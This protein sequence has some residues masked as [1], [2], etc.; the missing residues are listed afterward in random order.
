MTVYEEIHDERVAQD[1]KWGGVA[2]DDRNTG[3]D[4]VAYIVKHAGRAVV[5]WDRAVFRQQMIRVGALAVAAIE[6]CDRL[7]T[8]E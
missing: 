8:P 4:W 6:W 7:A 5:S 2:K 3:N 1:N